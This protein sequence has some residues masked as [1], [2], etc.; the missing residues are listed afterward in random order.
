[1]PFANRFLYKI[2]YDIIGIWTISQNVLSTEQHLSFVFL[3]PSLN[4]PNDPT[5]PHAGSE[6]LRQK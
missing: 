2:L 4:F 1:M 5:D 6:E 3:K